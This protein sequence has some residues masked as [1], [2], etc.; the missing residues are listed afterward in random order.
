[1]SVINEGMTMFSFLEKFLFGILLV[2]IVFSFGESELS[3]QE[4]QEFRVALTGKFPP[5]SYY[6]ENGEL[7]G[8]DVDVANAIAD[9]IGRNLKITATEWDGIMAGLL[10]DKYD[11]IISSMAITPER[12]RVVNFSTP[13]Y[14]SGAQ[15]FINRENPSHVYAINECNGKKIAV[16]LGETYQLYLDEKYP[17]IEVVTLKSSI[18]IFE[19]LQANRITGFVSDLLV[20]SWQIKSADRPF[21]PVGELLYAENIAIPV[22]KEDTALLEQINNALAAMRNDGSMQEIHNKY[23]GLSASH[24]GGVESTMSRTVIAKKLCKGFL[25]TLS[26]AFSSLVLGFVFAVPCAVVLNHSSGGWKI[27]HLPVRTLVDFIRGTPVLIQ[28]LFAW[29]G[30]GLSPYIAAICTLGVNSMAYMAEVIRAGLM[31]VSAGQMRAGRA[32]GLNKIQ[33]FMYIVWPQAFR[34]AIPPLMNSVVALTKDTALVA[35]ISVA[36]VIREAQSIISVTFQP[37]KYYFIV[38]VMFFVITF[39]LM[40]IAGTLEK[41]IRRRG[42]SQ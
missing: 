26:I 20:G 6:D 25:V 28:L 21:V 15:L 7:T 41:Q 37:T 40:K 33:I 8:F 2:V 17:N 38:A 12:A 5:F 18:E 29:M 10:A 22:R 42:F 19:L 16:V 34:V 3:A 39:P 27:L 35:V 1:M 9:R 24:M 30:L 36:E 13:Y 32:L 31:S 4:E 23:F 14:K 11:A